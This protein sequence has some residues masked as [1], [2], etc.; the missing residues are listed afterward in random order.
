MN[1]PTVECRT[2][3]KEELEG[4]SRAYRMAASEGGK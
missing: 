3:P 4:Q 1:A 2:G